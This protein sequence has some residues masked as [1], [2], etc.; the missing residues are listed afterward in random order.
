[1][2]HKIY[3]IPGLL[4]TEMTITPEIIIAFLFPHDNPF[5][6]GFVVCFKSNQ[7]NA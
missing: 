4:S 1:M 2:R 6:Q 7:V 3:I 5:A